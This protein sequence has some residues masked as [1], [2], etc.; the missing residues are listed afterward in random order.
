MST[1]HGNFRICSSTK[2]FESWSNAL[3]GSSSKR[4]LGPAVAAMATRVRC[5]SPPESSP[6]GLCKNDSDK[7]TASSTG[8]AFMGGCPFLALSVAR[9]SMKSCGVPGKDPD[10]CGKYSTSRRHT[11]AFMLVDLSPFNRT[12]DLPHLSRS[13]SI[14]NRVLFPTPLGPI[15]QATSPSRTSKR[16][17]SGAPVPIRTSSKV[18]SKTISPV[19]GEGRLFTTSKD[20]GP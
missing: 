5:L 8:P 20:A 10:S 18:T 4:T 6:H 13:E 9:V 15:R 1:L 14:F 16:P 11:W 12:T 7:P 17:V 3:V 19:L 2:S